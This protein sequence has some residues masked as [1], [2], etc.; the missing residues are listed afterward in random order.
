MT[1]AEAMVRFAGVTVAMTMTPGLDTVLVVRQTLRSGRWAGLSA[2][3]GVCLGTLVWGVCAAGGVAAIL[4]ASQTAFGVLR[5]AGVAFLLWMGVGYLR[6]AVRGGHESVDVRTG[7]VT[8]VAAF[9]Q[10]LV[11]NLLNPKMAVFYL[12]VLPLF[13]PTGVAPVAAGGA[14]AGVHCVVAAVWLSV[15]VLGAGRARGFLSSRR[16]ARTVDG[17]AGVALVGFGVALGLER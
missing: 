12:T 13:L 14:L 7:G 15:I 16:G 2:A 4:L 5:Y 1:L 17:V 6:S 10:G 8:A 9:R 11:T 3:L